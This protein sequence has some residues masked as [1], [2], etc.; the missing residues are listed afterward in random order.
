MGLLFPLSLGTTISLARYLMPLWPTLIVVARL[1]ATR[2]TLERA[3]LV[4][5]TGIMALG[6]FLYAN[7]KWI[8]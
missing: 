6:A 8:G 4:A 7:A 1:T 5:S 3:W 2:P